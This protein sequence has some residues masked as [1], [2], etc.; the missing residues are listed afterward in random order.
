M[1]DGDMEIVRGGG[2]VYRDFGYSDADGRQAKALLTA[3]IIKVLDDEGLSTRQ[4]EA[5]TTDGA[6]LRSAFWL[7]LEGVVA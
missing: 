2:N 1:T 4:A 6:A 5:R 3:Q 7:F